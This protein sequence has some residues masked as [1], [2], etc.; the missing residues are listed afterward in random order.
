MKKILFAL[1]LLSSFA[2]A[3]NTVVTATMVDTD[4]TTWTGAFWKMDF[5]PNASTPNESS[6]RLLNG[7]P[8]NPA[9]THQ[10]GSLNGSGSAT[11]T[12]YD[13]TLIA[14]TGS[15]WT[16][17]LCSL[18]NAPC[19]QYQFT[20]A[21]GT[22]NISSRLT[23]VIAAPRFP[24]NAGAYG[25]AD[26]EV[27]TSI[28][29]GAIYWNVV[30]QTTRVWNGT[31]WVPGTGTSYPG[32]VTDGNN[33]LTITGS[34][35]TAALNGVYDLKA[36]FGA[37]GSNQTMTC[38]ATASSYTLS[39]CT[40]GD[41][42]IGQWIVIPAAGTAAT[43][44]AP[45]GLTVTC[46][47]DNAGSCTGSVV[48]GYEIVSVQGR[49]NGTM[50]A[51]TS[52]VTVTQGAQTP[53]AASN[54]TQ[55]DVYTSLS[56]NVVTNADS[57]LVY[58]SINGGPY[59]FYAQVGYGTHAFKDFGTLAG[60]NKTCADVGVP[61]TAP[62]S[63]VS[64][65]V[66][67]VITAINGGTVTIATR[68][69]QPVFTNATGLSGPY[70]SQPTISGSV[71]VQ[72]DDTPA[73][74]AMRSTLAA[75]PTHG[76]LK[77]HVPAGNYI[78]HSETQL[79]GY[80]AGIRLT[81]LSNVTIE[82]DGD[83]TYIYQGN[84]RAWSVA[85]TIYAQCGDPTATA[86]TSWRLGAGFTGT[87]YPLNDPVKVGVNSITLATP[88]NAS[89]FPAGSY[90][91]IFTLGNAYPY[92]DYGELNLV[93]AS[94]TT[95]G[96]L[97]LAYPTT[98]YYS[99]SI[100]VSP[101]SQCTSCAGTPSI[102]LVQGGVAASNI[103]IRSMRFYTETYAFWA[104]NVV[105]NVIFEND[106]ITASTLTSSGIS[107]HVTM[108]NSTITE[109]G[110]TPPSGVLQGAAAN[111][112]FYF[113]NNTYRGLRSWGT[114]QLCSE[115]NANIN[116]TN[117]DISETGPA[118]VI[119]N[120]G[121]QTPSGTLINFLTC[122]DFNFT[123][124]R[125]RLVNTAQAYLLWW[126]ASVGGATIANNDIYIDSVSHTQ[127]ASISQLTNPPSTANPYVHIYN[128][129]IR[130]GNST[131]SFTG[132]SGA[133]VSNGPTWAPLSTFAVSA[134]GS[135]SFYPYTGQQTILVLNMTGNITNV[136]LGGATSRVPGLY[137]AIDF[138]QPASGGPFSIPSTCADAGWTTGGSG[139]DC[140]NGVPQALTVANS[141]TLL[142]LYDDGTRVHLTSQNYTPTA[143]GGS[144][145]ANVPSGLMYQGDGSEAALNCASGCVSSGEHWY[146]SLTVPAGQTLSNNS[147]TVPLVIR[148]TGTC[149]IGGTISA[150]ANSGGVANTLPSNY[151][152][153][154]GGGGF[155][156][157][158]GA[159]GG[160]SSPIGGGAAGTSG[161]AGGNGFTLLLQQQH[162]A[163]SGLFTA[164]LAALGG[165]NPNQLIYGGSNGG[166]GGSSG[167]AGGKGGGV[168]ILDCQTI[169]FTGTV[170]ASGQN[171]GAG[172]ANTGGGGGGGGG[173]VIL[174]SPNM[175]NSG[176]INIAGGAGGIIGTGTSTAG[177]SGGNGWSMVFSQ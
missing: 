72:H 106:N 83:A 172:G 167:G 45:T 32:V 124:N 175:T 111:T 7:Q 119:G 95:T 30:A 6:Y 11:I 108:R 51:A 151:G 80:Q 160:A 87:T 76:Q 19:G 174:R 169:N 54:S 24:P 27:Q 136:N 68:S 53:Q 59:N 20:S 90:I 1:L 135:F 98:K 28:N 5:R 55:P 96:V 71:T 140:P 146:A 117:N 115:G 118:S 97:T 104:H 41:F 16:L 120:G 39:G 88:S 36:A 3:Q 79:S 14:P 114:N 112:D 67:A 9:V 29:Q 21:G 127:A 107:R 46:G 152:G 81:G 132:G 73:F 147:A 123:N 22:M 161:V 134:A 64:N 131:T 57:Y 101:F 47:S 153:T 43:I 105:D 150:S 58:K 125:V 158:N 99:S 148:S 173:I 77:V 89:T 48:Y 129:K 85:R 65:D 25:Y 94:S 159:A 142:W 8:L 82:G 33:G 103:I 113:T 100:T 78:I 138:V 34:I 128:N 15:G 168:V 165:A 130:I 171:G 66:Y 139:I 4:G 26:V 137:F 109:D 143:S 126:D 37:S 91:T 149:A 74:D 40:G 63:P 93:T 62:A 23:T 92:S 75:L 70:P 121:L 166:T 156:A 18:T 35:S 50:T 133:P 52:A 2:G 162:T 61:C 157:A 60:V 69:T 102:A 170:D 164:G 163:L 141:H 12:I 31:I 110:W 17:T 176:T 49:P 145:T 122:F 116:V 44:A 144:T 10:T 56:W 155:G 154:G 13:S 177:G 38:A 84:D 42:K 86:C